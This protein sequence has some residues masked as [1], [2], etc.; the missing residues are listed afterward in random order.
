[1]VFTQ[2]QRIYDISKSSLSETIMK[3]ASPHQNYP[4]AFTR[5]YE[6]LVKI[7][8]FVLQ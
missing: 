4:E 2:A 1:M 7:D 3:E 6:A 8:E 5:P